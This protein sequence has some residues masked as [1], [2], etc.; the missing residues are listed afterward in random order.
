MGRCSERRSEVEVHASDHEFIC[1]N[2]LM[3]RT[4]RTVYCLV[5][6]I[7]KSTHVEKCHVQKNIL[8]PLPIQDPFKFKFESFG[9][10][11]P[12]ISCC[13][14]LRIF[15]LAISMTAPAAWDTMSSG[16]CAIQWHAANISII[17]KR[18]SFASLHQ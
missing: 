11:I 5:H 9:S 6:N 4:L 15:E 1:F 7:R 8:W 12:L 16:T 14:D 3:S 10:I 17:G 2:S 18:L 13:F